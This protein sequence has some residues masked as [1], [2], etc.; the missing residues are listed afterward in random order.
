MSDLLE[1][2]IN[3]VRRRAP[4][5]ADAWYIEANPAV[6]A[7]ELPEPALTPDVLLQAL[8]SAAVAWKD[9]GTRHI[10]ADIILCDLLL[11]ISRSCGDDHVA[12]VAAAAVALVQS[13]PKW[14]A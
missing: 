1:R 10:F 4:R 2:Y 9:Q 12:E 14:Y 6:P 11:I 8:R 3:D 7:L 5:L 13:W